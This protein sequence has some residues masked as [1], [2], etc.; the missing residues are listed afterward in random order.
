MPSRQFVGS[1]WIGPILSV[2]GLMSH[3]VP[4]KVRLTVTVESELQG[5]VV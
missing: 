2:A 1:P 4:L 3:D 5:A